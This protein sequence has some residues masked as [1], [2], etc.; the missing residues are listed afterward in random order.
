MTVQQISGVERLSKRKEAVDNLL[1]MC[2]FIIY[3][4]DLAKILSEL[5]I[6]IGWSQTV[7]NN[8][9]QLS[10]VICQQT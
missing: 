2:N 7:M 8:P 1:I 9:G 5:P 6:N 4:M 3:C 10:Q